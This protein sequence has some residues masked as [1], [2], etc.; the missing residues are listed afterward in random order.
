SKVSADANKAA[1][2]EKELADAIAGTG[3]MSA[4]A[5][6]ELGG[7]EAVQKRIAA[8]TKK[9]TDELEKE[10]KAARQAAGAA[11]AAGAGGSAAAKGTKAAGDAAR[12]TGQQMANLS[13]QLN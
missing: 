11:Q 2:A 13:Y 8:E 9:A 5:V 3:S 7:L 12:L 10:A 6:R 4:E 1:R